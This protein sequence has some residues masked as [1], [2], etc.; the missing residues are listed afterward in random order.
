M[1]ASSTSSEEESS[2]E[3]CSAHTYELH[4]ECCSGGCLK[5]NGGCGKRSVFFFFSWVFPFF[6]FFG[7]RFGKGS[8]MT[9][10]TMSTRHGGPIGSC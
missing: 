1:A 3:N 4:G 5:E 10:G 6:S 7:Y 2:A 9:T 8:P